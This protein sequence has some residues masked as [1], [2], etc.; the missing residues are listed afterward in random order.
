MGAYKAAFQHQQERCW[1]Q[2]MQICMALRQFEHLVNV[3]KHLQESYELIKSKFLRALDYVEDTHQDAEL[4]ETVKGRSRCSTN[5]VSHS[6]LT[7][8]ER[9]YLWVV[10][11]RLA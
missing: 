6:V 10:L 8:K 2:Y 5:A 7:K 3:T 11:L 9:N 1:A 4:V